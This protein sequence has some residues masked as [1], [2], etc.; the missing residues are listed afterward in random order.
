MTPVPL[1][2][3]WGEDGQ[4]EV[5]EFTIQRL[6]GPGVELGSAIKILSSMIPTSMLAL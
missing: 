4:Q 3:L 6:L 5:E 2:L 1:E